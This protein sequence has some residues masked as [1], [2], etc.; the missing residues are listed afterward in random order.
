MARSKFIILAIGVFFVMGFVYPY[1]PRLWPS[2]L[3][4]RL[5]PSLA[6]KSISIASNN[7][8]G[9]QHFMPT[10]PVRVS[11]ISYGAY[12]TEILF[13]DGLSAW[14]EIYHTDAGD[15]RWVDLSISPSSRPGHLHLHVTAN[16]WL[17]PKRLLLFD[18]E[19]RL[20]DTTPKNPFVI[21]SP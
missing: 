5:D 2:A 15:R 9:E 14:I 13:S 21:G 16:R 1:L 8:R 3:S 6:W 12:I 10:T 11:P 20:A 17:F 19:V 18:G 7:F 4:V